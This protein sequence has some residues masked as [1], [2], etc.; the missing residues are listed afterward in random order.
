MD[1][2][3]AISGDITEENLGI[4][5]EDEDVLIREVNIVFH[6]AATVRFDEALS[7]SVSMNIVGVKS[8]LEL[9]KKMT[10]LEALVDISTA[11][12]NCDKSHIEEKVYS[13]PM[14]PKELIETTETLDASVLD[15]PEVTRK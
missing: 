12:A 11:Y 13:L 4:S 3:Q 10:K 15:S 7:K 6:S 8:I 2:V 9:A 14:S 5:S 1:S